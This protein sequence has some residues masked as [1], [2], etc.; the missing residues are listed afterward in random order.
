MLV[1]TQNCGTVNSWLYFFSHPECPRLPREEEVKLCDPKVEA[2]ELP[3]SRASWCFLERVRKVHGKSSLIQNWEEEG[4]E[5]SGSSLL[6]WRAVCSLGPR[7]AKEHLCAVA[8]YW[9]LSVL[10]LVFSVFWGRNKLRERVA[11]EEVEKVWTKSRRESSGFCSSKRKDTHAKRCP[12][13]LGTSLH[14]EAS[15]NQEAN[16]PLNVEKIFILCW[17]PK[18]WCRFSASDR[19]SRSFEASYSEGECSVFLGEQWQEDTRD[20]FVVVGLLSTT[21]NPMI[22]ELIGVNVRDGRS[23]WSGN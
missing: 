19:C 22:V 18:E 20:G 15:R 9:K 14:L 8:F 16:A 17:R 7:W 1:E 10:I 2:E 11:G 21:T 6:S 12:W 5:P 13:D 3:L 23:R 4:L